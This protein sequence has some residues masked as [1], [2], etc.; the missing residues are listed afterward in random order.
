MVAQA[1]VCQRAMSLRPG[2]GTTFALLYYLGLLYFM[3]L[4]KTPNGDT[5]SFN[6]AS[7]GADVTA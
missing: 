5:M 6:C 2:W 1:G 7:R 3:D 4:F